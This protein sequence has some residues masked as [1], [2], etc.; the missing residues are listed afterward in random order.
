MSGVCIEKIPHSCGSSDGLQVFEEDGTYSGYCFVCDT[1]V[2]DPYGDNPP[3]KTR[4]TRSPEEILAEFELLEK[5]PVV[6][7]EERGLKEEALRYF[8]VTTAVSE[9]DGQTP[10][11][12]HYPYL[13]DGDPSG[14][15]VRLLED[16]RFYSVGNM[17]GV[18]LF[19]W[20]QAMG[21]G[22]KKLFITE[23]EDDAVAL[24]QALKAK[25]RGTKWESYNPAVVS[26]TFGAAHARAEITANLHKITSTFK[27]IV[28]VFDA[29][30]P[31]KKAQEDVLQVI[32]YA[33]VAELPGKDPRDCVVN[34]RSMALCN[35]VLFKTQVP[36]NTRL[37]YGS[38]L[39]EAGRQQA[40]WGLSW[41]FDGLTQLTRGMRRGET[42]YIGAGVKMGKS[43]V[44][45]TL[46]AHLIT[47][48][49]MKVFLAKPE[50]SNKKT[51]QLVC[52]KVA[53]KIFHDPTRE[54]D[55]DAYDEASKVIGDNL[56]VLNLYQH[57]GWESL[58]TDIIT[59]VQDGAGAVFIDP[60][61]NLVNGINSGETNT[62]LQEIAQ[63]LAALAKDLDIIIFIFCHLKAPLTGAPHERGGH[64]MSHQFSGSRAM[65]RS[66]NMMLGLE[67][68]KDPNL[69]EEARNM[70]KLVVLEDREFGASGYVRLYWDPKTSLFNEIQEE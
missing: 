41:P 26:L 10:V 12:M 50:E 35:A 33:Q 68:N 1:Y 66:C 38:E 67:G 65:M 3:T 32:P 56:I 58:R 6:A 23:G 42:Y 28:L 25:Q 31:G 53:G 9:V 17:K 39:H 36:K 40:Q 14:F 70:R 15:K 64:V 19:G 48:H 55:Y 47:E 57:L 52:G 43:E 34:G 24:F 13:I 11:A 45:N 63:E 16:K 37:V 60:I 44:V 51:Y 7:H 62:I 59:A 49:K 69:E 54:F 22:A 18:D 2:S 8:F 21:T 20:D 29:D 46:A 30:E 27:E 5:L 61:T 4:I